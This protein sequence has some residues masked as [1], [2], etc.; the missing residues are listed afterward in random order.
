M[1]RW[2]ML[3][4]ILLRSLLLRPGRTFTAL[5]AVSV[6]AAV[7]TTMLTLYVDVQA[8]LRGEFRSYGA[9]V[10]VVAK[11]GQ[12]L[13]ADTLES[14]VG[15]RI[16]Y[17]VANPPDEAQRAMWARIT[18]SMRLAA[19]SGFS[20]PEALRLIRSPDFQFPQLWQPFL[21]G[22]PPSSPSGGSQR[23]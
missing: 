23:N 5:A 9:N 16:P 14:L 17:H 8:K 15:Q 2:R 4:R 13:P 3:T 22:A 21:T 6:A 7:I 11:D 12:S 10:V 18:N 1:K 20:V 19:L